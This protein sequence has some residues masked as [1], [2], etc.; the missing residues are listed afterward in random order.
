MD[1]LGKVSIVA[2][3][4]HGMNRIYR[5][6]LFFTATVVFLSLS[7]LVILYAVGYRVGATSADP[8]PV[9]VIYVESFPRRATV[10]VND[11][12]VGRTPHAITNLPPGAIRVTINQEGYGS[13]EKNIPVAPALVTE[14]RGIRLFPADQKARLLQTDIRRFSLS[15]SRQT[16]AIVDERPTF[17]LT[18]IDGEAL[19]TP[20]PLRKTPRSLLWS[21][22]ST[23][24]VLGHSDGTYALATLS[25]GEILVRA[26]PALTGAD[27][28]V[29]DQR[30]PSRLLLRTADSELVFYNT[31]NGSSSVVATKVATFSTS[32]RAIFVV[33]QD[34]TFARY[35]LQGE[36][37]ET[38][39][40][41]T[42]GNVKSL[43]VTPAG[44]VAL[45]RE[46]NTLLLAVSDSEIREVAKNVQ[47]AAW[48]P[49]GRMLLIHM[50][51]SS[52]YVYNAADER[53]YIPEGELH[54][55]T[56]QS[57]PVTAAEWFAGGQH[58]LLQIADELIVVETDTRDHAIHTQLDTT[59]L[60][61]AF[62]SVGED[63]T[64]LYYLKRTDTHTNLMQLPLVVA[65]E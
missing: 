18:D 60:G 42:E 39:D 4:A 41:K 22:A 20:V 5:R 57:R 3:R 55:V 8:V 27:T 16:L 30:I 15:P 14:L 64:V 45:W 59:N 19:A 25:D 48:S 6:I 37:Q 52:I 23:G 35:N 63:G 2:E 26:M 32:T 12:E 7:P 43:F 24:V 34:G 13:W 54:L 51:N 47:R 40:W 44:E 65:A 29:W 49:D 33:L 38:L 46:D 62:A 50:D 56:R 1:N 17:S 10:R 21:P 28:V 61:D 53:S 36:L 31:I 9:G 11:E 58:L